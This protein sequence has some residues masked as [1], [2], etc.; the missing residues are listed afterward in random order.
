MHVIRNGAFAAVA[1]AILIGGLLVLVPSPAGAASVG[2]V[3]GD[4]NNSIA[5]YN[6]T[7]GTFQGFLQDSSGNPIVLPGLWGISF[8]NGNRKSGPTNFLYYAAGGGQYLTGVFGAIT[9]N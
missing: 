4:R 3:G 7:T 5:A 1:F 9:A 2:F 6:P 8:G